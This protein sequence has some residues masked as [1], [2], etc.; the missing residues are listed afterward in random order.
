[1]AYVYFINGTRFGKVQADGLLDAIAQAE[2]KAVKQGFA[3][4]LVTV[5]AA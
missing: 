5:R 4:N 1:M 3:A 2:A